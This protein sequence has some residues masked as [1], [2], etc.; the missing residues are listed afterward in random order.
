MKPPPLS[1]S[2]A[3]VFVA[4]RLDHGLYMRKRRYVLA[5]TTLIIIRW[6]GY[7]PPILRPP[8]NFDSVEDWPNHV[9]VCYS[10]GVHRL[11]EDRNRVGF[12]QFKR[13]MHGDTD[14]GTR[15]LCR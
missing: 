1:I 7:Y 3:I 8:S 6:K 10:S 15:R 11:A 14:E 9:R 5:G 12:I 4:H 2:L 13:A